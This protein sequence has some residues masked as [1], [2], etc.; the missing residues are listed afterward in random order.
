MDLRAAREAAGLTQREAA[1]RA[2]VDRRDL[3][4]YEQGKRWP[5][6][7]YVRW[8]LRVYASARRGR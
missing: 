1:A 4:R 6:A 8:L 2:R 3:Q 5:P 7:G